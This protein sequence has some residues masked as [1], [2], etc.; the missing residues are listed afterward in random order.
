[1]K[2][3]AT[4]LVLVSLSGG[5]VQAATTFPLNTEF[6]AISFNGRD[7]WPDARRNGDGQPL[8][9]L[10]RFYWIDRLTLSVRC[11]PSRA[12]CNVAGGGDTRHGWAGRV[13]FGDEDRITFTFPSTYQLAVWCGYLLPP[14]NVA[15]PVG[16]MRWHLEG[17]IL[18]L[19]GERGVYRFKPLH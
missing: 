10:D 15:P 1:M 7:L 19:E 12:I 9:F 11:N 13:D 5:A 17:D 3:G 14:D 4:L 6:I 8:S 2:R 18:I 16:P